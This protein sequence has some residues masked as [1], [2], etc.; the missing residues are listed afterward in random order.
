MATSTRT[1]RST[2]KTTQNTELEA[3]IQRRKKSSYP[4]DARTE[5]AYWIRQI[6]NLTGTSTS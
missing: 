5:R 2:R 1:R 6:Q 4:T 3:L